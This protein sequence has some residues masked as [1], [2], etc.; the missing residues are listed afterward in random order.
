MRDSEKGGK[1]PIEAV[2][3][4]RTHKAKLERVSPDTK[5]LK[6][7]VKL[8]QEQSDLYR[9]VME[10][11]HFGFSLIDRDYK[12][13]LVNSLMCNYFKKPASE[14]IG[15]KCFREF[16]KR[17]VICPHCPGTKAMATSQPAEVETEKVRDDGSHFSARIQAFPAFDSHGAVTGF[18][19]VAEDISER[20]KIEDRLSAAIYKSAIPTAVGGPD[21]SIIAFNEALE[22]L[23]GYKMSEVSDVT[24]WANKLYPDKEYREFVLRNIKQALEGRKQDCT[25]FIITCKDGST[26]VVDFHSSFFKSGLVIQMQDITERKKAEQTLVQQHHLLRLLIDN[27]PDR[28]YVKDCKSRFILGNDVVVKYEGFQSGKEL[29]GKTDF[30]LYPKELAASFY[31][32]EQQVI[33][34]GRPIINEEELWT[35]KQGNEQWLLTTKIPL[36]DE[37]G[38]I[39]GLVGINRNITERKKMEQQLKDAFSLNQ[40]IIDTSPVGIWIFEES[41]QFV[42]F[43]SSG[44]A[45]SG[46]TAER[47]LKQNFR[48]L[49][50]W[51]RSGLLQAAEEALLT[52]KLVKKEIHTVNTFNTEVWYE[53]LL[54]T[55]R[56]KG[57]KHLLLTTYDIKDR[58]H[59]EEAL[60]ET[61]QTLQ[62]VIQASPLPIC[63][64]D[65][66]RIVKTWNPAA[67]RTFGWSAQEV[68]GRKYP[69]IPEEEMDE[70]DALLSRALE[71]GLTEVETI[72]QRKDGSLI[73]VSISAAP[74]RDSRGNI[75]GV[76]AV[77]ADITGRKRAEKA[78]KKS[79]QL[80]RDTGE[81]A[82][83]GGW[84]VDLST[85]EVFCTE[86]T[87][88]I[89]GLEPGY[90][91]KVE[92]ALNF[93]A[94]ESRPEVEA[95]LKKAAETGEPYDLESLFIPSGSKNKIWV[96][97]IGRAV[98]S[99]GKIVKLAGTF[100]N[101]DKYKRA[102]ESLRL[103]EEK[104][105]KAF[106]SSPA[107]ILITTPKEGRFIDLNEIT[108]GMFGYTREEV[109]GHTS[110]ELNM[111]ASYNDR[112]IMLQSIRREIAVNNMEVRLRRKSGEVFDSIISVDIINIGG[113]E[114][115][116][117][118]V[119]D[120]TERKKAESA[121]RESE[122]K[123]R[124]IFDNTSDGMFLLDLE[125]K[126]FSMC[127]KAWLQMLGYTQEEF[128]NL[129]I[130][131]L[132][133][134]EDL[135]LIYAQ[136]EKFVKGGKGIRNDI[137]FKR[138]DGSVFFTDLSPDMVTLGGKRHILVFI[139]DITE[140]KKAIEKIYDYQQQL[141][142]LSYQLSLIEERA[143]RK[144]AAE[145][146]DNVG[147]ELAVAKLELQSLMRS[148]PDTKMSDSINSICG[149][150]THIMDDVRSLT[151]ELGNP[152]LDKIGL[153]AALDKY[154][155]EEIQAKFRIKCEL[156][157][158][159]GAQDLEET[160]RTVLYRSARELLI[161]SVKHARAHNIKVRIYQSA[162]LPPRLP[163]R[164]GAA[165]NI[166]V[167][168]EDDGVGFEVSRIA[169]LP[170]KTGGFGLFSI[171]EQL[172]YIGGNL[173]I[174]SSVGHGTKV[175]IGCPPKLKPAFV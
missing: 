20:K 92:E 69:A 136:V 55:I 117:S 57:K 97:S 61:T 40:I 129:T 15:K 158:E 51:K 26:K 88:R 11:T 173:Q 35:D 27:L 114:C 37:N 154:I 94:P 100:Q 119:V 107:A 134:K 72:R 164:V 172:E 159:A 130:E 142:A 104:F 153:T 151:F 56:F 76:M 5:K 86:E 163:T 31:A 141:K 137:G 133:L 24:D 25:E 59:S 170:T 101:I 169:L 140:R 38:K 42:M 3:K 66:E 168:V 156:I 74:L 17:D 7:P 47:L 89:H 103:S 2:E 65:R 138:K 84:E 99:G 171:K 113:T 54:S 102:E 62:A 87:C 152:L 112:D 175:T 28:V 131:D 41:G 43:N 29:L 93:Y 8:L 135:P 12:I 22:T 50:S 91:P 124:T 148:S 78:L 144:I 111:W 123:F 53:A 46:G 127:N 85:K 145:L 110:K 9:A 155:T 143:K 10:N 81:M 165:G 70:A 109:V 139:K 128:M 63:T 73:N 174:E 167:C 120:V 13:V 150:I 68:I 30:D 14:F 157:D 116:I 4:L 77:I 98:Y 23:I 18:I 58:K 80:L 121:L 33:Q 147:Q 48:E 52:G 125:V 67:E 1:K 44:V 6:K 79:N 96:R 166:H 161:N 32:K 82:K 115:L 39:V 60:R 106:S 90:L 71:S 21:G 36:R 146:H 162:G 160:V 83:V 34:K 95:V 64:L 132:H 16:E 45:L 75:N 122:Q 49:E 105:A 19:E 118:T 149:E 108:I 126:K